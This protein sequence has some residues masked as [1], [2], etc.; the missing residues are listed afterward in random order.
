MADVIGHKCRESCGTRTDALL[1]ESIFIALQVAQ[2][3]LGKVEVSVK[4]GHRERQFV[5]KVL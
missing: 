3:W 1:N 4:T 2:G 5:E